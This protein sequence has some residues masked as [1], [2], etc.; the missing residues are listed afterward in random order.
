MQPVLIGDFSICM[1]RST[2]LK[3]RPVVAGYRMDSFRRLSGPMM[4]TA[5]AV[6]GTPALSF[7]S[8]SSM[9]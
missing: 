2:S 9:P 7:S 5:R 4:N 8:G 1:E 3:L 6:S